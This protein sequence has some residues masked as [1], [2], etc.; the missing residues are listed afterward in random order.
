MLNR[1]KQL[2]SS[3]GLENSTLI[4]ATSGGADSI[5]ML[6]IL[7]QISNEMGLELIGAHLNHNIRG[8]ESDLDEDFIIYKITNINLG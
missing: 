1:V 4:A 3:S 6:H 7:S 5:A 2:I 8:Y